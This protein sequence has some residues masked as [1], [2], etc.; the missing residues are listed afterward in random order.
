[1]NTAKIG[2][3]N[4]LIAFFLIIVAL[5]S[6]LVVSANGWQDDNDDPLWET[7]DGSTNNE[8]NNSNEPP[9]ET[10]AAPEPEAPKFYHH[11]TGVEVNED[12]YGDSQ[13]AYVLDGD[14][15]L[16]GIAECNVL[17]EFPI[18]NGKTRYIM[19][20]DKG[21]D[22]AKIGSI[23]YARHF[24]SNLAAPFGAT[25]ISLGNDDYIEYDHIDISAYT[26]D[27]LK[28]PGSYYTEYT[29]FTYTSTKLITQAILS[30]SRV[31]SV[32]PYSFKVD[33]ESSS[34][35]I[36]ARTVSIP[37]EA[38]TSLIYSPTNK[39]YCLYKMGS[40]KVDV[41]TFQQVAFTNVLVLY[42]DSMTFETES[43][44]QMIM[45][46]IGYGNG[47]FAYGGAAEKISWS[48]NIDGKLSL[49]NQNGEKLQIGRGN[50]YIA[51]VKSSKSNVSIFQ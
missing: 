45:N 31:Q 27:L 11:I 6:V 12:K 26:V 24:M 35:S 48:M 49:F 41:S 37:Y 30:A 1:M 39:Q 20:A 19:I 18:E 47:Y 10:P 38:S 29:Y 21:A 23:T 43:Q 14:S 40:D 7:G 8:D 9:T 44:T 17:I 46:T 5:L 22:L 36:S 2:N 28:N 42:A 4:K 25:I 15:P 16:C 32:L 3:Y 34:G 33:S 13:V 50:T 51:Y